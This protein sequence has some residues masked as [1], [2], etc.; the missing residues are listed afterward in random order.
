MEKQARPFVYGCACFRV[1]LMAFLTFRRAE[2]YLA[3]MTTAAEF[4]LI[5]VVHLHAGAALFELKDSGVTVVA[6]K[7]RCMELVAE[8][9]WIQTAGR[10]REFFFECS[11]L[12][13]FCA[14]CRGKGLPAVMTASAE[15]AFIHKIHGYL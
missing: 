5:Y 6:F 8:D 10:I 3:V 14:V 7:H 11:H 4:A 1:L 12:V 15:I 2:R 13:A 9:R